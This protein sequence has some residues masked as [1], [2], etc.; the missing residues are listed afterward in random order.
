M[1]VLFLE[2]VDMVRSPGVTQ[3]TP[4]EQ[5]ACPPAPAVDGGGKPQGG[6][7]KYATH[8]PEGQ[9]PPA[10]G[11]R[12]WTVCDCEYVFVK[13]PLNSLDLHLQKDSPG[14][15]RESN[16]PP[17]PSGKLILMLRPEGPQET[18]P[19]FITGT[20]QPPAVKAVNT[21]ALRLSTHLSLIP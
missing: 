16:W 14:K 5:N 8:P 18:P 15:E 7:K 10:R 17:A 2:N 4:E 11:F 19:S 21:T 13:N 9:T 1:R 20:W 3:Q 6:A 12:P